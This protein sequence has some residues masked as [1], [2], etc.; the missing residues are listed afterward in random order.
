MSVIRIG[1]RGSKL[2]LAQTNRVVSLLNKQGIESETVVI[3][4]KGDRVTDRS[5]HEAGGVGL[6]VHELDMAILDGRID[7]A[8]HSM[9]DIPLERPDGIVT[10][11]VLKRD[12][13]FD[14][15][16]VGKP[17]SEVF[18]IGTSSLRR[19]AQLLRYYT[20]HPEMHAADMRG[21]IDTRLSKLKEGEVDAIILAE[22]GL[23]RLGVTVNGFRLSAEDFVP[24]ANQGTIA[25]VSRDT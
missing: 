21:N 9:K 11:A 6:F 17:M 3:S 16:V 14:F 7:A 13:P 10:A 20:G 5:L 22:A 25:V 4:T 12:P 8:V 15:L 24:S 19:R 2:A 18:R 1:T 23:V